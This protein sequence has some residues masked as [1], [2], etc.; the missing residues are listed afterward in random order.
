[1]ILIVCYFYIQAGKAK[2]DKTGQCMKNEEESSAVMC[3]YYWLCIGDGWSRLCGFGWNALYFILIKLRVSER[4][5][6]ETFNQASWMAMN[7]SSL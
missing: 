2:N 4:I 3:S 1:M 5:S 6:K 7:Y